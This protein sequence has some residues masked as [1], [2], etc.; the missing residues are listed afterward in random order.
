M[1]LQ[2]RANAYLAV[3]LLLLTAVLIGASTF[4]MDRIVFEL[5]ERLMAH[6]LDELVEELDRRVAVL[7]R[8][9]VDQLQDYILAAQEESLTHFGS[10]SGADGRRVEVWKKGGV[11]VLGTP[12]RSLLAQYAKNSAEESESAFIEYGDGSNARLAVVRRY[13]PWNWTVALSLRRDAV[14]AQRNTYLTHILLLSFASVALVTLVS[15]VFSRRTM[16]RLAHV[17]QCVH[18]ASAGD[19]SCRPEIVKGDDEI[20]RLESGLSMLLNA[21][22]KAEDDLRELNESLEAKVRERTSELEEANALLVEEVRERTRAEEKATKLQQRIEFILGAT[23]TGLDI[24]DMNHNIR[25]VDPAWVRRH[26]SYEG[27]KCHEY[28]MDSAQVCDHCAIHQALSQK[29][30]YVEERRLPCE[31]NRPIQVTTIP[32]QGEDGEWLVAEVKVDISERKRHEEEMEAIN[33][34]LQQASVMAGMAEVASGVLHNVGNVLN[35]VNVSTQVIQDRLAE[36]ELQGIAKAA[37]LLKSHAADESANGETLCKLSEYLLRIRDELEADTGVAANESQTL[38]GHIDHIR[39]IVRTQ[40]DYAATGGCSEM[41]DLREVAEDAIRINDEALSRHGVELNRD[42]GEIPTIKTYRHKVLQILTNLISNAKYAMDAG[43]V[44]SKELS[45]VLREADSAISVEVRDN[46]VGIS[47]EHMDELFR[48]GFTTREG[49]HGF[50]LHSAI[51]SA[52]SLGGSLVAQSEGIGK[53][54]SFTL[55]LPCGGKGATEC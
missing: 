17:E 43:K 48:H 54:A 19:L 50:G 41:V 18:A 32:F 47:P 7:K 51:L 16:R 3:M 49:G 30:T 8:A 35:S 11:P 21:R 1:K 12:S 55:T 40:Q 42:Y 39:E 2:T 45:L 23:N 46:G 24:I 4:V 14:L 36:L 34:E 44:E 28:F 31:G 29:K 53:G 25:Y 5:N 10:E 9:R 37:D 26:G 52:K 13:D 20:G 6:E 38:R 33:K 27:K 22:Q 15:Y